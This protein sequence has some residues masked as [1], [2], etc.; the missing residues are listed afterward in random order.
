MCVEKSLEYGIVMTF[1]FD[2]LSRQIKDHTGSINVVRFTQD[3]NYCMTGADDRTIKLWNPHKSD[4]SREGENA[5]CIKTYAGAHGYAVLDLAISLDKAKFAS[6]G[7]DKNFFF[8]D[9]ASGRIIRRF[10][11][12]NHKV[13][14]VGL[15]KEAT[16]V[17]SGSY[18]QTLSCWDLRSNNQ[19]PIQTMKDFRDSVS[20]IAQT[21]FTI[22]A[23]CID[24]NVRIYDMRKG[25]LQTDNLQDP[26]TCIR[27]SEDQ[28]TYLATCLGGVIRLVDIAT[29]R[30]LKEYRGH[31]HNSFKTESCYESD[32]ANIVSGSEDGSIVHWNLL[33]GE[34]AYRTSGAHKKAISAMAYHPT[35]PMFLTASYDGTVKCWDNT[36]QFRA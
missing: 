36:E 31:E 10:Q 19:E 9:V 28:N 4:P 18:D 1:N 12:H 7:E 35:K 15:N 16:V 11:G 24:G 13:N 5:L 14:T 29:G 25:H 17:I 33:S 27:V 21:E 6:C 30:V 3:G 26:I 2:I 20:S 22:L 23:S 32:H 8:W 34:V